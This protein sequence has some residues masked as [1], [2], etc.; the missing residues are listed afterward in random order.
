MNFQSKQQ[1]AISQA[2]LIA[3]VIAV[4]IIAVTALV[5]FGKSH[6]AEQQEHGEATAQQA[7]EQHD[8]HEEEAIALTQKQM[9]AYGLKLASVEMG[10]VQSSQSLPSKL[11]S[12]LDQKAHVTSMFAGRVEA[13]YVNLNQKVKKGQAL[14]QI[15]SPD[16][17]AQQSDLRLAKTNL[18]LKQQEYEQE[19]HLSAEGA[20]AKRDFQRAEHAYQQ[21][22]IAVK[23]SQSRLAALGAELNS[24]GR[25]TLTAPMSGVISSKDILVG[26]YIEIS[27]QLL[28]IDEPYQLWLELILPPKSQVAV[29]QEL[30]FIS[31]QSQQRFKARIQHINAQADNQT[32]RLQVRATVLS[33][34]EELR[35]NLMVNV[36]LASGTTRQAVRIEKQ[37]IQQLEGK[38]TVFIAKQHGD[39]VE[40]YPQRVDLGDISGE[41]VEVRHGLEKG[42][43]YLSQGSFLLKSESEKGEA[44]H[45]H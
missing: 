11:S 12:N 2:L 41:W 40:F 44:A 22:Q 6:Q 26:E 35:P 31:L 32:G 28:V 36:L 17:V 30:E 38:D 34:A 13:V 10:E 25:Y 33:K 24:N 37:A 1:G 9:L 7:D 21:A 27:K 18:Q 14:A 42:Q 39:K 29:N 45:G 16:L 19:K 3:M 43:T 15:I 8:E 5:L 4:T 23:E 20:T